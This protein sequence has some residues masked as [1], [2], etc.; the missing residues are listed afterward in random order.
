MA[1]VELLH[2]Q[3]G[4]GDI[5]LRNSS[6]DRKWL[7]GRDYV[8]STDDANLPDGYVKYGVIYGFEKYGAAMLVAFEEAPMGTLWC[9]TTGVTLPTVVSDN[10]TSDWGKPLNGLSGYYLCM[11]VARVAALCKTGSNNTTAT[12]HPSNAYHQGG[13]SA[14]NTEAVFLANDEAVNLYGTYEAYIAQTRPILKSA[15]AG[16]FSKRCG[17]ANTVALAT[18]TSHTYPAAQ[19]CYNY[20][21]SGSGDAAGN[22]WLPDMYEL[23]V[24]MADESYDLHHVLSGVT[25]SAAYWSCVAYS[26]SL[27][28]RYHH[29]GMS[30]GTALTDTWLR[31]RPVT[32]SE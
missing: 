21:V 5:E 7:S 19:F 2:S 12:T 15:S 18:D 10:V 23:A 27:A 26:A 9:E 22:W 1:I 30:S 28:W 4:V 14:P 29:H 11:N 8:A 16:V 13:S 6:G 25:V 3:R 17:K 24:M 31:A 20:V 32:I